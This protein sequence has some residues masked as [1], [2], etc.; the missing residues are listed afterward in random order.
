MKYAFRICLLLTVALLLSACNKTVSPPS[1]ETTP[2]T[3]NTTEEVTQSTPAPEVI[4]PQSHTL[5]FAPTQNGIYNYCPTAMQ[6]SDGTVYIYYCTNRAPFQ[7]ID[8]IGCRKGIRADDGTIVWGEEML[9]LAPSE[10]AWDAHHVCDP[11]VIE[12]SFSYQGETYSYLMAYLG[13]TS[14]DNQENKIGLAVA[15]SPEGPFVKVGSTPLVDF[16]MDPSITAFQWGVGQPSLV[17]IDQMGHVNLF[18][19]RGDKSGTRLMLDE[20]DLSSLD[21]PQKI[22]TEAVSK[23]G[24]VDLVGNGDFMNNVDLLYDAHAK[25]YYAVS[26]CHPNPTET[27]SFISSHFRINYCTEGASFVT[28][29]GFTLET[30]SPTVT[31]FE[32]NHNAGFLRNPYGHL[33]SNG[34]L[35]VFYT[36]SALGNDSL[37][38]YRVYD[39]HTKLPK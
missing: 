14:Y 1:A 9:V 20:W 26:D 24:L 17:S 32:R 34:Y 2:A 21:A 35:T 7:V 18:Y 3:D 22:K 5:Q 23:R 19:T 12:G 39:H 29:N 16:A 8:Y 15:K 37:W 25:R 6:F 38:S 28:R 33:P 13:C 36:V 11:S 27:P 30:V 4:P 31:G 10:D